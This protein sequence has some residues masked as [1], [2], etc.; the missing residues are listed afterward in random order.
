MVVVVVVMLLMVVAVV[1]MLLMVVAVVRTEGG[2]VSAEF[3]TQA[4][5]SGNARCQGRMTCAGDGGAE[6]KRRG[7]ALFRRAVKVAATGRGGRRVSCVRN[8]YDEVFAPVA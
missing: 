4:D 6:I 8:D 2:I 5:R 1:V 7:G 3:S